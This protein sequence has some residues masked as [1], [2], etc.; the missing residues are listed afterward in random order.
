MHQRRRS[1]GSEV[2][3]NNALVLGGGGP[4]G[5]SWTSALLNG[6]RSAGVALA[7]SDVVLGTSAGSVVG[8]WLT[9]RPDGLAKVPALMHKRAAWHASNASAG[10]RDTGLFE[11]TVP[12]AEEGA[13]S[14]AARR[15]ATAAMPP[16]SVQQADDL[17]T[18]LLPEGAWPAQL[19]MMSVNAGTGLARAWS[20]RDGIPLAVGVACSTA[21]PGIAPPVVVD[22]EVWLD[23]AVRTGTNAD[24]VVGTRVG[25]DGEHGAPATEP[26]RVL[27]VTPMPSEDLAREEALLAEHGY[28]VR[29]IVAEPFDNAPVDLI[30]PR[31]I[32][33]GATAGAGQAR[34]LAP[35]L[36]AWW[37]G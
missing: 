29:V 4:V 8:A 17:W 31:F 6:L 34:A 32:D 16:I 23:G 25:N 11:T 33:A 28:R 12:D 13:G 10:R 24:L 15:A 2:P 7:D 35:E 21:A 1:S 19:R 20:A 26:G 37:K 14:A 30:D 36:L 27:V 5:A 22:G 18:A 3:P 9:I